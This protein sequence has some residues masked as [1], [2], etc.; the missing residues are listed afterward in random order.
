MTRATVPRPTDLRDFLSSQ[1]WNLIEAGLPDRLFV[2]ENPSFRGRQFVFPIDAE[3][4]DYVE[5]VHSV[6]EKFVALHGGSAASVVQRVRCVKDDV[7]RL[8]VFHHGNDT[9]LPLAFAASFVSSAER[10]IKSAASTVLRPRTH[11]PRLGFAEAAQLVE[12]SRLGQTEAGS[13]VLRV[14]CPLDALE[15]QGDLIDD[16]SV[17]FVRQVTTTLHKGLRR[18]VAAIES[19]AL[20]R[21]IEELKE[22]AAPIVSSNWCEALV[23]MH[24]GSMDNSLDVAI[25]WS[26]LERM[27]SGAND[28]PIRI[29]RDY[30][31]RLEE[32]QQALKDVE[33][34]REDT[35]IGTVERLEGEFGPN[36]RRSGPVMLSLLLRDEQEAVRCRVVLSAE[37]YAVAHQAH[38]Q[39]GAYVMVQGRLR[40]G[41]QPRQLTEVRRF[42]VVPQ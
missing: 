15:M 30:F 34:H 42:Q 13:F 25:E 28:G 18:L 1:G 29:Q 7:L 38:L 37:D 33:T 8:R 9:T 31:A 11:H 14:E 41:R 12:K 27:P 17:P 22:S 39:H 24:D 36:G 16:D 20:D 3:A 10:L 32:V 5:S 2:L 19:D 26:P 23:G 40:P 21:F 6:I 4:P 35:F